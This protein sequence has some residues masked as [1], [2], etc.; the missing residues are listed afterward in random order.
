VKSFEKLSWP[1]KYA[2][3]ALLPDYSGRDRRIQ[4][5]ISLGFLAPNELI[6]LASPVSAVLFRLCVYVL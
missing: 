6:K 1:Q 3:T 4:S 5:W 2:I